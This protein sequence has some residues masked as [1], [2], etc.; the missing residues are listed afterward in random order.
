[1]TDGKGSTRDATLRFTVFRSRHAIMWNAAESRGEASASDYSGP[2]YDRPD[3]PEAKWEIKSLNE[4]RGGEDHEG[5]PWRIFEWR[6]TLGWVDVSAG[7]RTH[8]QYGECP[9]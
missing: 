8:P 4:L 2:F 9:T 1:M 3:H 6:D 5:D 7:L